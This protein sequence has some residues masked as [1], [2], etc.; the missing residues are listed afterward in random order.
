M[1]ECHIVRPPCAVVYAQVSI[2]MTDHKRNLAYSHRV[3]G[4]SSVST[5][6]A[7]RPVCLSLLLANGDVKKGLPGVI[8][9]GCTRTA[10]WSL[11]KEEGGVPAMVEQA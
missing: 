1:E 2:P 3:W 10:G 4:Y 7:E 5:Q 6:P 8:V 11:S 9:L